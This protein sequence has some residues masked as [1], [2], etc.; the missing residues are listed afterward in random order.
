MILPFDLD[1]GNSEEDLAMAY[2]NVVTQTGF[3][4]ELLDVQFPFAESPT[5]ER[6]R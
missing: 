4:E 6:G 2:G 5:S 3:M 1:P